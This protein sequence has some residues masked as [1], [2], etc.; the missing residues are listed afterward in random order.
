[1]DKNMYIR[2]II[3][4][5]IGCLG[6]VASIALGIYIYIKEDLNEYISF[7]FLTKFKLKNRSDKQKKQSLVAQSTR[8]AIKAQKPLKGKELVED[9][10]TL[11]DEDTTLLNENTTLLEDEKLNL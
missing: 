1:M 6:A 8:L 5:I 11:L 9:N 4:L 10:T 3:L 7:S 2:Y